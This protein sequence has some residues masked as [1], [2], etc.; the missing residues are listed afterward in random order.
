MLVNYV[1]IYFGKISTQIVLVQLLCR[2][3]GGLC[4][5]MDC[6]TPDFPVLHYLLE[7]AQTPLSQ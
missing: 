7:L 1:Y 3:H 4:D 6:S 2:V 5:P